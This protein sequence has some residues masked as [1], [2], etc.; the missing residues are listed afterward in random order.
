MMWTLLLPTVAE[1]PQPV[2]LVVAFK[3]AVAL[4]RGQEK[5]A[6]QGEDFVLPGDRLTTGKA[7]EALLLIFMDDHRERVKPDQAVT[8]GDKGCTPATAVEVIE[9]VRRPSK[10]QNARLLK[11]AQD[12]SGANASLKVLRGAPEPRAR[13][14]RPLFGTRVLTDHPTLSWPPV[15]G[16]VEY[17]VELL[18]AAEG[19]HE[20]RIWRILTTATT[21]PY[22]EEEE[23]L[24][25]G[26]MYRWRVTA[27]LKGDEEKRAVESNFHIVRPEKLAGLRKLAV[28][29]SSDDPADWLQAVA[30]YQEAGV[31]D[32]A[33]L[34][35]EKLAARSPEAAT[36]LQA[37]AALYMRAGAKDQSEAARKKAEELARRMG[38]QTK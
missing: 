16:A 31:Y 28:L 27:R 9:A 24:V 38:K 7:G 1:A 20:R 19:S 15:P 37:L 26:N 14:V 18:G 11:H 25:Y 5:I 34:L 22:P 33:L 35:Y 23:V 17:R 4:H 10:A 6:L 30:E 13:L 2:G 8:V 12:A 36:Y 21:L 29:A 32:K 3:G